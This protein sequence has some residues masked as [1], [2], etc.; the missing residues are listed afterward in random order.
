MF[1]IVVLDSLKDAI[2][3]PANISNVLSRKILNMVQNISATEL[4]LKHETHRPFPKLCTQ[5]RPDNGRES[6]RKDQT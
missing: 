6:K 1:R 5:H 4:Y 3:D 2:M